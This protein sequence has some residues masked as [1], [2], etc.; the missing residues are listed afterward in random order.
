MHSLAQT[1]QNAG[2]NI[3][4]GL[5]IGIVV[6]GAILLFVVVIGVTLYV[7][8][9]K[10]RRIQQGAFDKPS[11][12]VLSLAQ[13]QPPLPHTKPLPYHTDPEAQRHD[14]VGREVMQQESTYQQL[15]RDL[16]R[17]PSRTNTPALP[18]QTP[19]DFSTLSHPPMKQHRPM[20]LSPPPLVY[21]AVPPPV[22]TV[23]RS[24]ELKR[25][26]SVRSLDTVSVYSSASAPR[27]ADE[28]GHQSF[29]PTLPPV[30]QS[31]S[32]PITPKWPSSPSPYVWPKRQRASQI[33][34]E[35]APETYAKVRWRTDSELAD[36][37]RDSH[38]LPSRDNGLRTD[39]APA[40]VGPESNSVTLP[41][42]S[43]PPNPRPQPF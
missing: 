9:R 20:P 23:P 5:F 19:R 27:D 43:P 28:I 42:H 38:T 40:N 17:P 13:S 21:L 10:N 8:S 16:Q 14:L 31:P 32:T 36:A 37:L 2:I 15:I 12:P 26:Q 39:V 6:A 7:C 30:P 3:A 22:A 29:A 33:R 4:P 1:L 41:P 11:I 25:G 18:N 24:A 34:D 35:L